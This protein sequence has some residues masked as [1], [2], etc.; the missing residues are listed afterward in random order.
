MLIVLKLFF[1]SLAQQLI[2]R[3]SDLKILVSTNNILEIECEDCVKTTS[4]LEAHERAFRCSE[5]SVLHLIDAE[6]TL[7]KEFLE[8]YLINNPSQTT[9]FR[10]SKD[11]ERT[12]IKIYGRGEV[13]RNNCLTKIYF[14]IMFYR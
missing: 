12:T 2:V 13:N 9:Y 1:F 10:K 8:D 5:N 4:L 7:T 11:E 14:W 3:A 6:Y